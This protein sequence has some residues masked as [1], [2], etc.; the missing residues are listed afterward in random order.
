MIISLRSDR[1]PRSVTRAKPKP[2]TKDAQLR[3]YCCACCRHFFYH[4]FAIRC[5]ER[6]RSQVWGIMLHVCHSSNETTKR[7]FR[8]LGLWYMCTFACSDLSLLVI[9]V[10]RATPC[11]QMFS[12]RAVRNWMCRI[13]HLSSFYILNMSFVVQNF[14]PCTYGEK[15]DVVEACSGARGTFAN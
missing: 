7:S 3:L 1:T 11:S 5:K 8:V 13:F 10:T 2:K 9:D 4:C 6:R 14:G 12:R 15:F